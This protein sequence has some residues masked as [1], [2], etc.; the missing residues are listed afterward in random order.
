MS[1]ATRRSSITTNDAAYPLP[2]SYNEKKRKFYEQYSQIQAY[3]SKLKFFRVL[4][5]VIDFGLLV[6]SVFL[7]NIYKQNSFSLSERYTKFFLV[8]VF[9]WLFVSLL[10]QKF[11]RDTYRTY[12]GGLSALF[13]SNVAVLFMLMS[14]MV[15]GGLHNLS[16]VQ[17][18]GSVTSLFLTETLAFMIYAVFA[19]KALPEPNLQIRIRDF[20][21]YHFS[22][23]IFL[24]DFMMLTGAFYA[25]HYYKRGVFSLLPEYQKILWLIYGL[26]FVTGIITRKFEVRNHQNIYHAITPYIK[27]FF[28]IFSMTAIVVYTFHLF[29]LSRVQIFGTF[30]L[31]FAAELA[32]YFLYYLDWT[33]LQRAND[34]HT[35]EEVKEIIEGE[36]KAAPGIDLATISE[37]N[38]INAPATEKLRQVYLKDHPQLFHFISEHIP[39][40]NFDINSVKV[41]NTHTAYNIEVLENQTLDLVINLHRV[42]D[43]RHLN[44]YFLAVHK[45][46]YNGGFLVGVVD[47]IETHRN[48]LFQKFPILLARIIYPM[49]FVFRRILPKLPI[50]KKIYFFMTKGKNRVISKAETLGRLSF[51]GFRVVATKEINN[52]LYFIVQCDK[53]PSLVKNPSYGPIIKLKRIGLN[54][55]PVYIRKFRTMHPYSEFLQKYV[56]EENNL[57]ENGKF[58]NDFRVTEWGKV[59]RRFWLDELPQLINFIQG[60][61]ALVGVRALSEHYFSLYPDDLKKLRVKFKPGLFP[62]Y[63]ADLPK[64]FKEIIESERNYL[65]QKMK[66]P[67]VT[68]VKYFAKAV[69]NILFKNAR[70]L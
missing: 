11:E 16:R 68:D 19:K 2:G 7:L 60:D 21:Q 37:K 22:F 57:E 44:K 47:T 67:F 62:P 3:E 61:L 38:K 18:F 66:Q 51:C 48:K 29:Y 39:L 33:E 64:N 58:K 15:L 4:A 20:R 9:V 12:R 55:E 23:F 24:F 25:F 59:L 42:N 5:F 13:K 56:Y 28:I 40:E 10:F 41:L 8:F 36:K 27:S 45:K 14:M 53:N 43:F 54:G 50:C 65:A 63:Y 49:D 6:L 26:W 52:S 30:V 34:V 32:F 46:I 69:F 35:V 31:W 70:S 17:T 1:Q